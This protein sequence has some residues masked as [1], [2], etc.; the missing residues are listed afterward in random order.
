MKPTYPLVSWGTSFFDMD[1]DGWLD[2]FVRAATSIHRRILI[3]GGTPYRQPMLLFRNHRDGSFD[4][5][6]EALATCRRNRGGARLL[7]ISTTT[8]MS[9]SSYSTLVNRHRCC[10]NRNDSA[11]HRVLFKLV[12]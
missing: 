11:N 5:V 2:L 9:T 4:D 3:P 1:N 6:S 8:A 10:L 7:A 12:G